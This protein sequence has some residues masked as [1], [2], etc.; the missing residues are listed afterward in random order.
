MQISISHT[1]R[2][3]KVQFLYNKDSSQG[4][5]NQAFSEKT[6]EWPPQPP[7]HFVAILPQN[8]FV[9]FVFVLWFMTV[10]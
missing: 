5:N 1:A 2:P 9:G 7:F 3:Q 8:I 6:V 4:L 10:L